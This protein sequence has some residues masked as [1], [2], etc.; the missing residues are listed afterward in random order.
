MES[1]DER[2]AT[3]RTFVENV[4]ANAKQVLKEQ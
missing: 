3:M 2:Q 1:V 4:E